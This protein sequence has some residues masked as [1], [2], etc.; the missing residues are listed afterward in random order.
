VCAGA[1]VESEGRGLGGGG[2][3]VFE[4][5]TEEEFVKLLVGSVG[6]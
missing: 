2:E 3:D 1:G 5:L 6:A 4:A